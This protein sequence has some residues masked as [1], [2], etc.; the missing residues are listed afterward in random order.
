MFKTCYYAA[1]YNNLDCL[2]YAHE[3]NCTHSSLIFGFSI[4]FGSFDCFKY[5]AEKMYPFHCLIFNI[6]CGLCNESNNF[7]SSIFNSFIY[8]NNGEIP[9]QIFEYMGEKN[10]PYTINTAQKKY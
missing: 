7:H 5:V 3:N 6:I 8:G 9:L 1:I 10:F 2:K 4:A